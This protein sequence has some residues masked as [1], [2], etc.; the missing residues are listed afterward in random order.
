MIYKSLVISDIFKKNIT[1]ILIN[2]EASRLKFGRH[3]LK[4]PKYSLESDYIPIFIYKCMYKEKKFIIIFGARIVDL[5]RAH[6]KCK[7]KKKEKRKRDGKFC[8]YWYVG[9]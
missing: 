1:E 9:M 4:T 7:K 6:K 5:N 2:F 3:Q 8:R